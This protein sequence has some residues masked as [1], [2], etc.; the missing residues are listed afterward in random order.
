MIDRTSPAR[1]HSNLDRLMVEHDNISGRQ[2]AKDAD[3]TE[4]AI[5]KLR[6]N[7]FKMIDTNVVARVCLVL[8]VTPAELFDIAKD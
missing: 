3:T 2:L 6:R 7:S 5:T 4:V 8:G 1:L